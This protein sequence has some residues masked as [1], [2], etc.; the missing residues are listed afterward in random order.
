MTQQREQMSAFMDG[1]HSDKSIIDDLNHEQDLRKAWKRYHLARNIMRKE[2]P[3]GESSQRE[4]ID[5]SA[6]V[7]SAIESEPSI[8]APKAA[9]KAL[10]TRSLMSKLS[11]K[12]VPFAKQSGQFAVAA[13]VAAAVI[14]GVQTYNKPDSTE[15]FTSLP[16]GAPQG[17]LAP[18]S[19]NQTRMLP[20]QND[21]NVI[22]A[23][24]Q[25]HALLDDHEKQLI[26]KAA[27][28]DG[29]EQTQTDGE[30]N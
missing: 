27:K 12:V 11:A 21:Q 22:E 13:S 29:S 30:N 7:A 9:P 8:L 2:L 26:L 4:F 10:E 19:F 14:I 6:S 20:T 28:T 1:E 25:V 18:V 15:P 16:T 24:R 3:Q 5:I 23:R 17:G